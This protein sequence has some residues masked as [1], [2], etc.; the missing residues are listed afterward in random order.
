MNTE[1]KHIDIGRSVAN[2][3]ANEICGVQP[4]PEDVFAKLYSISKTQKELEEEGY[5]P[6]SNLKLMYVKKDTI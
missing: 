4:M 1:N 3:I 5:V 6:V 2:D